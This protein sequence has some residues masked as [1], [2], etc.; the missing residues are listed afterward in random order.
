MA[1]SKKQRR[2]A[3]KHPW[4]DAEV[5]ESP[6]ARVTADIVT[7]G[8]FSFSSPHADEELQ[9]SRFLAS[10]TGL[11]V[12]K[13]DAAPSPL[14]LPAEGSALAEAIAAHQVAFTTWTFLALAL[15]AVANQS[16]RGESEI[17][18][19]ESRARVWVIPTNEE[20]M[21]ARH[22]ARVVASSEAAA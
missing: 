3:E 17:G 16:A 15:D 14:E 10:T 11:L 5:D 12:L 8:Q 2:H 21:I 4:P 7:R 13:G 18:A 1:R 22:T 9:R 19:P 20:L 6:F